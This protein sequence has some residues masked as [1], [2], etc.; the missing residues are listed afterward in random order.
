MGVSSRASAATDGGDVP[1]RRIF[2]LV[3]VT[4][5]LWDLGKGA[6]RLWERKTWAATPPDALTHRAADL[7]SIFVG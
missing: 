4:V 1:T 3:L 7:S 5:V 2:E 6:I